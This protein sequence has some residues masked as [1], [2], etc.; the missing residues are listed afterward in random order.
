MDGGSIDR[1]GRDGINK[2]GCGRQWHSSASDIKDIEVK[3]HRHQSN[4]A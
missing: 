2:Q 3:D 4:R 1:E